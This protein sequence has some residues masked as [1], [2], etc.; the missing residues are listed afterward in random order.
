MFTVEHQN[1]SGF[2]SLLLHDD[3]VKQARTQKI[4]F[5]GRGLTKFI[6]KWLYSIKYKTKFHR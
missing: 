2:I 1:S 6:F 5:G 3:Y 4:L